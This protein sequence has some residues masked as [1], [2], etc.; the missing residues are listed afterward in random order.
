MTTQRITSP[1]GS[2]PVPGPA[3]SERAPRDVVPALSVVVPCF[4]QEDVIAENL[5]VIL[6]RIGELDVPFEVVLVSDGS[7]DGTE[8]RAL[9]VDD[10]RVRVIAYER[11]MGKGYALRTGSLAAR[12]EWVAWIDSDLDLD[13][14]MLR[15][16][17]DA[18]RERDLEIVVGSKRHPDSQVDYPGRRRVYSWLYQQL[19]R[20]LFDLD[21]RDTQVGMKLFR[22]DVLAEVL[23][24]VVVKRYAFDLEILAVAR[25]FGA[26]RIAEAPI[27]LDY[28]FTG[29]GVNWR[30]IAQALWDT[31][32][33]FHRLRILRYYDRRRV[34]AHR[35]AVHRPATTPTVTVVVTPGEA[36]GADPR[37]RLDAI[38]ARIPDGV[39]LVAILPPG[40]D[41]DDGDSEVVTLRLGDDPTAAVAAAASRVETDLVAFVDLDSVPTRHW[42]ESALPLFGDP[43]VGAVA[44]PAVPMITGDTRRDAAGVLSESRLGVAGARVRH[45]V[46]SV[47]E[48]GE[49]PLRNL[50]VRTEAVRALVAEGTRLDDEFCARMMRRLG[51]SVLCSP[52][53][54]VTTRPPALYRPYLRRL[55]RRGLARGGARRAMGGLRTRHIVP[56]AF[57]AAMAAGP[58]ALAAG[59][60]PRRAWTALA[61]TYAALLTAFAALQTLLHRRPR[62]GAEAAAGAAAS[63][64]AFGTGVLLGLLRRLTGAAGSARSR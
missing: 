42:L 40:A 14:G 28:R 52:D 10:T 47:R 53:V 21:V 33:V 37:A 50:L 63:H 12:G 26:T 54:L 27:R 7:P 43:M 45:H 30:A 46:G 58:A 49:F 9:E 64:V 34:L 41:G 6:A 5:R 38:A 39:P 24:V 35:L 13:P 56:A 8:R 16:F 60:R 22:R 32:A 55:F 23:P 25:R 48:I 59:G 3:A 11:N 36:D 20:L 15:G 1:G 17:L 57:V 31:A 29:T 51:V 44:G 61:V 2:S 18:A 62:L 4:R 19:V